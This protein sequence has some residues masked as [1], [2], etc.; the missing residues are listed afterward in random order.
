MSDLIKS[1]PAK[2]RPTSF[3]DWP[4]S[5]PMG[6]LRNEIDR[7]FETPNRRILS[8]PERDLTP[9]PA[10]EMTENDANYR[11]S[12]EL[13]GLAREDIEISVADGVLTLSGEKKEEKEEND[14][15]FLLS[16]RRYGAFQRQVAL[17]SDVDPDGITAQFKDGVLTILLAKDQN[18]T[19]RTRKIDVSNG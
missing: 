4:A 8:W 10:L 12:A 11:L 13:P 17:P 9:V 14:K 2:R 19:K 7:I 1:I 6:W 15:G 3:F 5:E 18:S 16:E